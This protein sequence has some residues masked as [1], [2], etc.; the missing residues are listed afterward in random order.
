MKSSR[1]TKR[2]KHFWFTKLYGHLNRKL[3]QPYPRTKLSSDADSARGLHNL[4]RSVFYTDI[5]LDLLLTSSG[6]VKIC[7]LG[8]AKI[9]KEKGQQED[10]WR[11]AIGSRHYRSPEM[12]LDESFSVLLLTCG[13]SD[14]FSFVWSRKTSFQHVKGGSRKKHV[15]GNLQRTR[16]ELE[17]FGSDLKKLI[18]G[19]LKKQPGRLGYVTCAHGLMRGGVGITRPIRYFLLVYWASL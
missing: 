15:R 10:T 13:H 8:M 6:V 12:Y 4:T 9:L 5:K 1:V 2:W 7:D 18:H 16:S 19:M 17:A 11:K 3:N 14:V